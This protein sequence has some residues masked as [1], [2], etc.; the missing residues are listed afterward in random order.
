MSEA[1]VALWWLPVGA[2]GH[3]VIRTSRWW[4]RHRARREHRDPSPLFHAALEVFTEPRGHDHRRHVIEMAPAWGRVDPSAVVV[5][6]GPVGLACLGR[7]PL[8]RY[9]VRCW[10]DGRI[11]DRDQA[12]SPPTV[13]TLPAADAEEMLRRVAHVPGHTW[14]R[15]ALGTGDMWNSNSLVSWL[16]ET[17][18]V[19]AWTLRP[20][21][22]GSAPGWAAG[23]AAARMAAPPARADDGDPPSHEPSP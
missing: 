1:R 8:F 15:D 9:A 17:S 7:T 6:T 19:D 10:P 22:D 21:G 3:V 4:E 20:P 16:L 23:I 12:P 2:G 18:G 13:L 5:A 14:G 11:P